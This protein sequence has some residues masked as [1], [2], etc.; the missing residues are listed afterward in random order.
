VSAASSPIVVLK[1]GGSVLVDLAAYRHA[2][3]FIASRRAGEPHAKFVVVVSAQHGDTDA[4]FATASEI[5]ADPDRAMVDLLWSTG[6][7]RSAALLTLALQSC[8]VAAAGANVHEAGIV[9][10]DPP[11]NGRPRLHPLRLRRLLADADV[12]VIPG[13]LARAGGDRLVSLGRGGSDLT[14][15]V[16]AAGLRAIRCELIKDVAGYY[17]S[18]PKRDP[19]ARHIPHLDF[20]RSLA[21][22][23]AGCELVQ[24]A[25]LETARAEG[26][27]L[28][29]RSMATPRATT[30][31][32]GSD[33][34]FLGSTH[35]SR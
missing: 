12:V 25:A 20:E 14:A 32:S 28:V 30:L 15:V 29:V 21:L 16:V 31:S 7:L 26:L 3:R 13:F 5:A 17:S 24:R 18:D 2:A 9:D 35:D 8:G 22:A 4:L 10:G 34:D 33:L 1:I 11:A 27:P 6:E 19:L 23:D